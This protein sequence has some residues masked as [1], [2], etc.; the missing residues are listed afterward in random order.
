M[1]RPWSS[2]DE[3]ALRRMAGQHSVAAIAHTLGRSV[4]SVKKAA[5]AQSI[6]LRRENVAGANAFGDE[7]ALLEAVFQ[8]AHADALVDP[9]VARWLKR[10]QEAVRR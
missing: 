5:A 6:S 10:V 2:E 8:Q 7:V 1:R 4:D 3:A 9:S